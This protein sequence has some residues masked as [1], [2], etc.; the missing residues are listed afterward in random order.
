MKEKIMNREE[1]ESSE[2]YPIFG[3]MF[4]EPFNKLSSDA[5]VVFAIRQNDMHLMSMY[6]GLGVDKKYYSC[7]TARTFDE[8]MDMTGL[9]AQQVN[10]AHIEL[11][12]AGLYKKE[13]FNGIET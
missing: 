2:I 7:P 4:K 9:T 10:D 5:K 3:F 6:N 11:E 12:K 8:I 13:D 1:I